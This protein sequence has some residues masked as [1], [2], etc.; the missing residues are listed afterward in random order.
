MTMH[1]Q[2][3]RQ[4]IRALAAVRQAFRGK[5]GRVQPATPIQLLALDGLSGE[6]GRD[7]EQFQEYGFTSNPPA[8]TMAVVLPVGGK[9][10]HGIVVATE[11]GTYRLQALATGEVAL[12]SFEGTSVVLRSGRVIESTCD[13]FRVKCKTYDVQATTGASFTTPEL[14]T[15]QQLLARGKVTGEGGLAVSGGDG[16]S[17]DGALHATDDV[18]AGAENI[19][20][21]NHPHMG[22]HGK[23]GPALPE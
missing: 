9:T 2:I 6:D 16:V 10:S 3:Q 20:L 21:V 23:T 17:V 19:S 22:V 8:G 18:T 11:H 1:G 14:S 7:L 15:S 12:Y 5:I 4:I 13:V